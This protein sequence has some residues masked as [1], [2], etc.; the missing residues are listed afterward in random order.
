MMDCLE[1]IGNDQYR[2][3]KFGFVLTIKKFPFHCGLCKVNKEKPDKKPKPKREMPPLLEQAT[4]LATSLVKHA[5]SGFQHVAQNEFL[6]RIEACNQ[7]D[8]FDSKSQRCAA[9]GCF[10]VVKAKWASEECPLGKWGNTLE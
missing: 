4:N 7:C 1:P 6:Q 3:K 5:T 9:C 8:Q 2:C 10:L